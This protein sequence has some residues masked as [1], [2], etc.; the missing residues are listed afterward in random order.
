MK[1]ISKNYKKITVI[2]QFKVT[3]KNIPLYYD[4][5]NETNKFKGRFPFN[6]IMPNN[7]LHEEISAQ[8]RTLKFLNSVW[9]S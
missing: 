8:R 3:I 9:S 1:F 6:C 4:F 2:L 5:W 7:A